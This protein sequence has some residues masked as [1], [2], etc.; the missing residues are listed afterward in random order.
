MLGAA[1]FRADPH[2]GLYEFAPLGFAEGR[3]GF[4]DFVQ[5][6]LSDQVGE[7]FGRHSESFYD[8]SWQ[9]GIPNELPGTAEP[10]VQ[11]LALA[12]RASKISSPALCS[13]VDE[14]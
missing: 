4:G 13:L 7:L 8:V 2:G 3:Y 5:V 10:L 6:A 12:I 1:E 9:H 11:R 14:G